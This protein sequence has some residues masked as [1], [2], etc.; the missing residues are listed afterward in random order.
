KYI[1][2]FTP[3]R[4]KC[5][6]D[7]EWDAPLNRIKYK[8][9]WCPVYTGQHSFHLEI[10]KKIAINRG[11]LYLSIQCTATKELLEWRCSKGHECILEDAKQVAYNRN[12]SCLSKNFINNRLALLWKCVK[13]HIWYATLNAII[14]KY[15]GPQ[16]KLYRLEFL[17]TPEHPIKLELDIYY[18]DYGFAIE[19][20]VI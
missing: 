4:W 8:N 20:Q 10:A 1:N 9:T 17:K 14:S 15:L 2:I 6:K 12:G 7:H 16:S 3:L 19:V 18:P 5:S 13:G 11:R